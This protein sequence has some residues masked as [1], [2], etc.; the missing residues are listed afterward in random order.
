MQIEAEENKESVNFSSQ[1]RIKSYQQDYD[2]LNPWNKKDVV[3]RSGVGSVIRVGEKQWMLLTSA[4][5]VSNATLIEAKRTKTSLPSRVYLKQI[6]H[7][8]NLALLESDDASFFDEMKGLEWE[9]PEKG[10]AELPDLSSG[11]IELMQGEIT[12]LTVGHRQV[13]DAWLPILQLSLKKIC[14]LYT[15]PSPR[16]RQKSRMPSSA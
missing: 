12:G 4:D 1:V 13:R 8:L 6:D 2:W 9:N 5:L 3:P 7:A 14:L 10:Q 15:S 16:D 11:R